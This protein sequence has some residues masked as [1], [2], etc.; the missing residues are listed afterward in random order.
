M[1]YN[2]IKKGENNN[3]EILR[4]QLRIDEQTAEKIK[5]IAEKSE[6]S[7]NQQIS[8]ILKQFINDYEKVNGKIEIEK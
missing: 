2:S 6:R 3:M 1:H 4:T 8:H 5:F 7:M